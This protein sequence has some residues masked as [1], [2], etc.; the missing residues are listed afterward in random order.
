MDVIKIQRWIRKHQSRRLRIQTDLEC[1]PFGYK[2][3]QPNYDKGSRFCFRI[4]KL[5]PK[6]WGWPWPEWIGIPNRETLDDWFNV[7]D[8]WKIMNM[9]TIDHNYAEKCIRK[10]LEY[11]H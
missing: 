8:D 11:I 4:G 9:N 5:E 6:L 2:H 1:L 10:I 7:I 3:K